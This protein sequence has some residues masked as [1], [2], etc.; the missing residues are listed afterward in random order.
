MSK[1]TFPIMISQFSIIV[2][3]I[4]FSTKVLSDV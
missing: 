1:V 4:S 2:L 3:Y